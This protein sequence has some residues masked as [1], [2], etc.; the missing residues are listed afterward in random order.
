MLAANLGIPLN[1]LFMRAKRTRD[2]LEERITRC[3][4]R[5]SK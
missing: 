3:V 5:K 4:K 2:K 1:T